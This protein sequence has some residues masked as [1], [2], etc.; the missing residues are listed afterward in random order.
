MYVCVCVCVCVW[1]REDSYLLRTLH[2]YVVLS[3]YTASLPLQA[4]VNRPLS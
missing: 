4:I 1:K 3:S 2:I